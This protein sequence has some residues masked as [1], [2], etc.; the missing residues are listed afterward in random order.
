MSG[1]P[2]FLDEPAQ[3]GAGPVAGI[4]T[5]FHNSGTQ[6]YGDLT[7][8]FAFYVAVKR[9]NSWRESTDAERTE[10]LREL[11]NLGFL[12]S[13][14]PTDDALRRALIE[15]QDKYAAL[16]HPGSELWHDRDCRYYWLQPD[17]EILELVRTVADHR[18]RN[19][20]GPTGRW[21]GPGVRL[22]IL[23]SGKGGWT[24]GNGSEPPLHIQ[25]VVTAGSYV[26]LEGSAAGSR[27][28][29]EFYRESGSLDLIHVNA[30]A[31]P[32]FVP[33]VNGVITLTPCMKTDR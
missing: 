32:P 28:A 29:Y 8:A 14:N 9:A 2:V 25:T 27:F 23:H 3:S 15:F 4:N 1:G 22:E 16:S 24:V 21:C 26:S 19:G 18:M 33:D 31:S 6:H 13:P 20:S 10:V 17:A 30:S 12:S 11:A 5:G 7:P